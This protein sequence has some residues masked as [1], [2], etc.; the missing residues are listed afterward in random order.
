MFS[1]YQDLQKA[2]AQAS[3]VVRAQTRRELFETC[4][5]AQDIN[6]GHIW[7]RKFQRDDVKLH[8][9][10]AIRPRENIFM[11]PD[12]GIVAAKELPQD[13]GDLR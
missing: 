13:I 3:L 1:F 2:C 11:L 4:H 12:E 8:S 9:G 10:S 6:Y 7:A 5:G